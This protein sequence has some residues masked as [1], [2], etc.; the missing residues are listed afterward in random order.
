MAFQTELL[1]VKKNDKIL[2]IGTGSGYQT[3][4]LCEMGAKVFSIERHMNLYK[5]AK[6]L[7]K[8][9]NYFPKLKH[10]DGYLGIKADSHLTKFLLHAVPLKLLRSLLINLK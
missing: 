3:A 5:K 4:V 10:G 2:E 9:L 1:N 8:K 7:L 6:G